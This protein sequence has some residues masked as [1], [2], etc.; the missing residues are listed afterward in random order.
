VT[1][2]RAFL[3]KRAD[4]HTDIRT[5]TLIAN[6]RTLTAGKVGLSVCL[7]VCTWGRGLAYSR[8][9][10]GLINKK[11]Q[12]AIFG[13]FFVSCVFSELHAAGFRPAP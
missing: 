5:D 2:G 3:D 8:P 12:M 11:K 9:K 6:T 13:D 1:F 10:V 7:S 4:R